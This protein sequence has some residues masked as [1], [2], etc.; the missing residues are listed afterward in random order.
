MTRTPRTAR[1]IRR[2]H[3]H[4]WVADT[5]DPEFSAGRLMGG[6]GRRS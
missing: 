6:Y 5:R 1:W 3:R 4:L 2:P